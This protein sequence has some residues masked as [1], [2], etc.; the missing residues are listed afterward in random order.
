M[1]AAGSRLNCRFIPCMRPPGGREEKRGTGDEL[2][3]PASF[4]ASN[5]L[6]R[7]KKR[8]EQVLDSGAGK[9]TPAKGMSGDGDGLQQ[10]IA[11]A[12][13]GTQGFFQQGF[14]GGEAFHVT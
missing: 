1:K 8:R 14:A 6:W 2:T 7:N 3:M 11:A 13:G 4:I 5:I 12:L 10:G 9:R